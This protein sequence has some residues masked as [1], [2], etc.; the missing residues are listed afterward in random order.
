M[1]ALAG[2]ALLTLPHT[3]HADED[4]GRT[5]ADETINLDVNWIT[6]EGPVDWYFKEGDQSL[7]RTL[8]YTI[9][10]Q[11]IDGTCS[12][13][14]WASRFGE[15]PTFRTVVR[16]Q[17]SLRDS[18]G[19]SLCG[20]TWSPGSASTLTLTG[21]RLFGSSET[22]GTSTQHCG[23]DSQETRRALGERASD[24]DLPRLEG[25]PCIVEPDHPACIADDPESTVDE[26]VTGSQDPALN[27]E[28]APGAE[29]DTGDAG[30]PPWLIPVAVVTVAAAAAAATLVTAKGAAN[31]GT[32]AEASAGE[33]SEALSETADVSAES[34][35]VVA[36][37]AH[38]LND[39]LRGSLEAAIQSTDAGS[40]IAK[41][42]GDA[43]TGAGGDAAPTITGE[44]ANVVSEITQALNDALR[45]S[46]ESTI[47]SANPAADVAQIIGDV[48]PELG[49]EAASNT[50][51]G[52]AE[53][54]GDVAQALNDALRSS[55]ENAIQSPDVS[56][57]IAHMVGDLLSS[58]GTDFADPTGAQAAESAGELASTI[59]E[60]LQSLV[61]RVI[62][63]AD[64]GAEAARTLSVLRP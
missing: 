20:G 43:L 55:L 35:E 19:G 63:S 24:I 2:A 6:Y 58:G 3:A 32:G 34:A 31:G 36:D 57:E 23:G 1:L 53:L 18:G 45:N 16:P 9:T 28:A 17:L 59:N 4:E 30:M 26:N 25:N 61:D 41:M 27:G 38:S 50:S 44:A 62:E 10:I 48:L 49:A 54:A 13:T 40:E 8:T 12:A 56:T 37:L 46:L 22:F 51:G 5:V 39:F 7:S 14:S 29:G 52:A 47:Q 11:C 42:V 15:A 21:D 64:P 33:P 60:M